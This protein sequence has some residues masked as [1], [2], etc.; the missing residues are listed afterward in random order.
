LLDKILQEAGI[1]TES[2][3]RI[4]LGPGVVGRSAT[5]AVVALLVL[6]VAAYKTNNDYILVGIVV[7]AVLVFAICFRESMK[8][9][10]RNPA[11]ALLEGAQLVT[12]RTQELAAKAIA[13]PPKT[14][15]IPDPKGPESNRPTIE[16]PDI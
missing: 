1:N 13:H 10:D 16:G 3:D 2:L 14:P 15:A 4:R 8:Y 12:W 6:G 11:A 7:I 5:V 9:A